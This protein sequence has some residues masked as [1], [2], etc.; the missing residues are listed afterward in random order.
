VST[1][2]ELSDFVQVDTSDT[3]PYAHAVRE[4]F[5]LI[6]SKRLSTFVSIF[7]S[8]IE[9]MATT[10]TERF[11][12]V[13]GTCRSLLDLYLAI[14]PQEQLVPS[15]GMVHMNECNSISF[16]LPLLALNIRLRLPREL[17]EKVSFIDY[18]SAFRSLADRQLA[19]QLKKARENILS[20]FDGWSGLSD[21][22]HQDSFNLNKKLIARLQH[23]L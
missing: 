16:I 8:V 1:S 20:S 19:I 10:T 12:Q 3:S 7:R 11:D 2:P 23:Q 18:I 15:L 14:V 21:T 13:Y 4:Y 17:S 5:S 22:H 9:E 6:V